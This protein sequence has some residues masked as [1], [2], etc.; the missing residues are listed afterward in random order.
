MASEPDQIN[1]IMQLRRR[2]P[3]PGQLDGGDRDPGHRVAEAPGDVLGADQ[4]CRPAAPGAPSEEVGQV[5]LGTA[6]GVR[7]ADEAHP[8]RGIRPRG[9]HAAARTRSRAAERTA[10]G[11]TEAAQR[12]SIGQTRWGHG[13]SSRAHARAQQPG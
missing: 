4:G 13:A 11:R 1:L 3:V 12:K 9:P 10:S 8:R 7:V 6:P 2:G 5:D